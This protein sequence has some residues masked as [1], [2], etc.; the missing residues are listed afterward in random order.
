VVSEQL[1]LRSARGRG[2][3][4]ASTVASGMAFLDGT[5]VNVALPHIGADLHADLA[6]L[7]WTVNAYTLVLAS[8][9]LL[10][11]AL[12]DRYGRRR[13]F[14]VGVTWFT[15]ASVLCGLSPGVGL[16]VGARA[17]QGVGAALLTPSSLALLQ[18]SF[19]DS[20]RARAIGAWSG[21][22]GVAT[23]VG[24]FV[25]G[26]LIDALSWRWIFFLNVPLAVV[27][28]LAALA[29][30]S[31]GRAG[32]RAERFD[33]LGAVLGA[34]GL[35][36]T[37]Y[38]LI[39]R[40]ARVLPAAAVGAAAFVAFVLVERRRGEAAML[41]L[42]LFRRRQFSV[43]NVVTLFVYAGLGGLTFFLIVELQVVAGFSAVLAGVSL[44]PLTILLLVGS[45]R[46][47]ALSGRIGPR[48]PLTAGALVAA[49]GVLLMLRVGPHAG[50]WVDVLPGAV[51]I[52]LGLTLVVAPLTAAVLAAAPT[53]QSGAASGV[54]NAVA[55]A[56]SLLAVAALPLAVGIAGTQYRQPAALDRAF[57][58]AL[59]CC[60][61]LLAVGAVTAGLFV[62]RPAP[63]DEHEP[64]TRAG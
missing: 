55:R 27:A 29:W 15:V 47:G 35:A 51:L 26:W 34:L 10:G 21:L 8:L 32:G 58:A 2:A 30:V 22:S 38:A 52:G 37:A 63:V 33:I 3:V 7:Q 60:A 4:L 20:D 49:G 54:S 19:V 43:I 31:E 18:S 16:L 40:G 62:R 6:G 64:A 48:W 57:H 45:A 44:L 25:G 46:A 39:Q 1:T 59:W 11:G 56:G 17:L 42:S 5:V 24:P 23:A 41:P 61:G 36:G 28:V 14:L 9:V 12:G 50:Y 13:V 53:G